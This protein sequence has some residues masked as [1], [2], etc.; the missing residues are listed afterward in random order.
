MFACKSVYQL[1][2]LDSNLEKTQIFICMVFF[3]ALE[4]IIWEQ[5]VYCIWHS[6]TMIDMLAIK[7][8]EALGECWSI[9][10]PEI[11]I[12][13]FKSRIFSDLGVNGC[14]AHLY[15]SIVK[16]IFR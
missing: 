8:D 5:F 15:G 12:F 14:E 13:Y 1:K 16:I 6:F 3:S 10:H 9:S 7:V 4:I 11:M 2:I